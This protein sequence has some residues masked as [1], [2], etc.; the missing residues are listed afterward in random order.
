M[1]PSTVGRRSRKKKVAV[2]KERSFG[3]GI[4][5]YTTRTVLGIAMVGSAIATGAAVGLVISFRNLPDVRVLNSFVP[6]ETT[7]IYDVKGRELTSLHGEANRKLVKLEQVSPELKR[8][9]LAI[10]DSNFYQHHGIN[11]ISVGRALMVNAKSGGVVEGASTLTMQLVKNVF[12][13]PQ[14]AIARK[15]AEAVLA[16]R[17]E[18]VFEKDEILQMYLNNIYWGH[19]NYGVQTASESYFHKPAS[20]LT[21]P[22]AAMLAGLVQSPELYSPFRDYA[23]AKKRQA[24]V[25]NRM[26]DLGW[27][28]R[29]EAEEA[30]QA[31][32]G[33]GKPTAWQSSKLPYVTDAVI[34]ELNRRFGKE[35]VIKGGMRIQTTVDY[36]FQKLAEEKVKQGYLSLRGRG[37][38]AKELQI[39]LVA[40]DP[41]THF[42]KAIVG[43]VDY[44]KS[45]LNRAIQSRRQPG[46]SF[47][48]FVYYTAFASGKYTPASI[49][50]DVP[51][52]YRDGSGYYSP[53]NYGGGYSGAMSIRTALVQSTNIP[54]IVV[55]Q[56]V[57]ISKVIE[58][59]KRLGIESPLQAVISLPLGA[60][61]V[62][63]LEMANAFAT[64][65]SN[66]WHEESTIILRVTDSQGNV[67]LDNTPHPQLVLDP[68]AAAS[69]TATLKGVINGGTGKYAYI[70]RPAAGKTGTTDNE[71]NVWFVGYVPQLSA[72]VWVGDDSNRPLGKGVSGGT[73]A[74]PVW[75]NFMQAA[76]KDQ[77]VEH[78]PA[79]SNFPAPAK[80]KK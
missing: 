22:E 34:L 74:A 78:F 13:E 71:R 62:T 75:R 52:R 44:T 37:I 54:A 1:S 60:V 80:Q 49:V 67:L 17:I 31:K 18:Q 61:E 69:L 65:A 66:G 45:Q 50:R 47:K 77:P 29:Q 20:D 43:G 33:I 64:F 56:K 63:P 39:A 15:M 68:W 70:G 14:R 10:E 5:R 16:I 3:R 73:H 79:A 40:V 2:K 32:L 27:I 28:T 35:T 7:F 25:L 72:A 23:A 6:T 8:A 12:L 11:L 21:L 42:V 55:G 30:R 4:L 26:A 41:R 36:N 46:S 76:L 58:L 38:S 19:N 9:L 57:G 59:C 53:K 48:P 51:V 24:M